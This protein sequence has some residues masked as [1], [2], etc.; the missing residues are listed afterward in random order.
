MPI[1]KA[2]E[3]NE[4]KLRILIVRATLQKRKATKV[5][6]INASPAQ[7]RGQIADIVLADVATCREYFEDFRFIVAHRKGRILVI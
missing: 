5:K 3:E 7:L 6:V 4:Q 1:G 2:S